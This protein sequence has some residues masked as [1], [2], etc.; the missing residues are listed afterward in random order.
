MCEAITIATALAVVAAGYQTYS[1]DQSVKAQN[2]FNDKSAEEGAKLANATFVNQSKQVGLRNSQEAEAAASTLTENA[3]KAAQARAT[4]RVSAGESGVAGVSVDNLINDYNRQEAQYS[5]A[6]NRN[7]ELT[8]A[9]SQ[10]DL[11]GLR[12]NALDRSLSF[13]RPVI[14]R[15]SYLA[16][17]IGLAAQGAGM[18]AK[19]SY[20]TKPKKG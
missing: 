19:Y 8:T 11:Q 16:S 4:A 2:K 14:E 3:Q 7:L 18:Y 9:Q 20:D 6:V 5:G 13:Q 15:P 17:G 1:Q 10:E 12:S